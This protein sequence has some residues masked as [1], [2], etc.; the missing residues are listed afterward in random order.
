MQALKQG[1]E[2]CNLMEKLVTQLGQE[3]R[4][5]VAYDYPD[6][7]MTTRN[8]I[9]RWLLTDNSE[10]IDNLM[11]DRVEVMRQAMDYRYRILRH[12]YLGVEPKQAYRNLTTRLASVVTLRNKIRTW[13]SLSRDRQRAVVDVLQEVIQELLNSDRY[14][15]RQIAW[16]AQCTDNTHLRDA[17]LLTTVEEYCL[18]PVR[19]Q[20][21]L[22]YRFVNFLKRSSRG[23]M[24]NVPQG[25]I[26]R[27]VSDSIAPEETDT[28]VSLLDNQ[29][30]SD[31]QEAQTW[32]ERQAQR[33][34]V[35]REF[36]AYLAEN[37]GAE[38]AEWL[39]LYL[40]GKSPEAIASALNLPTQKVYRLR[41]KIKYH[42]IQVFAIKAKPELVASWLETSLQDHNLGLTPSQW[43]S[44]CDSLTQEQ[45]HFLEQLKRGKGLDVIA[46][47]FNFKMNQ[48]IGEWSKLY[49]AAQAIRGSS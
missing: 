10:E 1:F 6:L 11:P 28:S 15:Q 7:S 5:R 44:Y 19:N 42:A 8:S 30:I 27:M 39:R 17:L 16:I 31:Y 49:L 29:A 20:P 35:R 24:T 3:W 18:R 37:L 48:A 12:R 38:A 4:N 25:E 22:A 47:E 14:I 33:L 26:V 45:R 41:E 43:Q 2:E 13:V 36:E 40:Q 23:G 21:L 34:S 9:V 46:K 32:E